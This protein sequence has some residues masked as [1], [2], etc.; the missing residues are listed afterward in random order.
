MILRQ[1]RSKLLVALVA[2]AAVALP[3]APLAYADVEVCGDDPPV[4]VR[5]PEGNPVLVNN[6]VTV[7]FA[8]RGALRKVEVTGTAE[9]GDHPGTSRV[10]I[11]VK[12]PRRGHSPKHA[13][14]DGFDVKV[15]SVVQRLDK[16]SA[17]AA[18]RDGAP[19]TLQ[20]VVPV[21]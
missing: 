4:L 12:V 6:F 1:W 18:G 3:Q 15:K 8:N 14:D 9:R 19:I 17:E 5:T 7:P 11:T 20:L 16:L 13:A 21:P 10:T 2:V